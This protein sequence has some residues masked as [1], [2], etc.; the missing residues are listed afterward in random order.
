MKI[1]LLVLLIHSYFLDEWTEIESM[2]YERGDFNA[3][4]IGGKLVV[5]GGM[6]E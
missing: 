4:V 3:A 5:L 2:Q 1:K 6:G